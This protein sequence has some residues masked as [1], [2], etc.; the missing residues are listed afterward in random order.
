MKPAAKGLW[1]NLNYKEPV[2]LIK[3]YVTGPRVLEILRSG[4]LVNSY[5][6]NDSLYSVYS[7]GIKSSFSLIVG[8][9]IEIQL[10]EYTVI[11][12]KIWVI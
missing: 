9:E 11:K 6:L 1:R 4:L 8:K 5:K 3:S 10:K 7:R 2:S 12:V